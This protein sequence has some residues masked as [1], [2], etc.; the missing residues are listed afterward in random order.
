[1]IRKR[2]RSSQ[3]FL[4]FKLGI[5]KHNGLQCEIAKRTRFNIIYTSA[6]CVLNVSYAKIYIPNQIFLNLLSVENPVAMWTTNRHENTPIFMACQLE[7][8]VK[9]TYTKTSL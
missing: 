7:L 3:P 6:K 4:K 9:K 2:L 8:D 5:L 1:M